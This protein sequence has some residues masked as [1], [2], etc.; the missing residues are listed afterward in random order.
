MKLFRST[1]IV[2]FFTLLSRISGLIRDQVVARLFGA[3]QWTDVFFVVFRIPNLMRRL[4][5]EGSFS[6]AFIPVLNEVK[7][8]KNRQQL[9][10]FVDLIFTALLVVLLSTLALMELFAPGLLN[11]FAPGFVDQPEQYG[12]AVDMLRI[13]LPYMLLISLVALSGGILNSHGKFAIPALTPILLNLSLIA[14]A[15]W[16]RGAFDVPVKSL[17]YGVLIA[18]FLQLLLQVPFLLRLG[19]LPRLR[20]NFKDPYVQKVKRL[21]LPTLFGSSVAQVNILIDTAI[22]TMLPLVGS[23]SYLYYA[24]RLMEFPLGVF[25]IAI[26]TV[27]LPKLSYDFANKQDDKLQETIRWA[28]GLAIIIAIPAAVALAFMAE[29]VF[30]TLF[31]YG[32]FDQKSTYYSSV[33]LTFYMLGLPAFILN[34]VLLPIFF[35]RKDVKTP[36]KVALAVMLLN[37]V[38][39]LLFVW[40][41][42]TQSFVSLHVGLALASSVCAWVQMYLLY[43]HLRSSKIL[44][45]GTFSLSLIVRVVFAAAV[46]LLILYLYHF[47]MPEL[48]ELVWYQRAIHLI[49]MVASGGLVYIFTLWLTKPNFRFH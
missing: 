21:M 1:A 3:G 26:A 2:S 46:M 32:A 10:H 16:L 36:V 34:K 14:S 7:A 49:A 31:Q 11:I 27:I 15:I 13:S 6:L 9:K 35:S 12:V 47:Y 29:S 38:L 22:A 8:Q 40:V 23:I 37:V 24:D 45:A 41:L 18:G 19:M 20:L 42:W 28:I 44:Y 30:I 48:G 17:A 5:A 4:F 33:A 43:R 25:G 39:N